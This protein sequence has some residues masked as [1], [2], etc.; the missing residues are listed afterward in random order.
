MKPVWWKST[1]SIFTG[2]TVG[3]PTSGSWLMGLIPCKPKKPEALD[4]SKPRHSHGL[5]LWY[6][7]MYFCKSLP[8]GEV[9][10]SWWPILSESLK[11]GSALFVE[12]KAP[13]GEQ[14]IATL[15]TL[16]LPLAFVLLPHASHS[17]LYI[18]ISLA[19]SSTQDIKHC[20]SLNYEKWSYLLSLEDTVENPENPE[21][22]I[23]LFLPT[24]VKFI[25][26][27]NASLQC[28]L[29]QGRSAWL[30]FQKH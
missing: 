16:F 20:F 1:F 28:L 27:E 24:A 18:F 17:V 9:S 6:F 23:L 29:L 7:M 21:F 19:S 4:L 5:Y 3:S 14:K 8:R 11:Y 30:L 26:V 12:S 22:Q 2:R 25:S 15:R 10:S 13:G